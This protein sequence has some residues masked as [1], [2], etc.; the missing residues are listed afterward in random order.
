MP[1]EPDDE[2]V[3]L[4]FVKSVSQRVISLVVG[5]SFVVGSGNIRP[6]FC[7]INCFQPHLV[8]FS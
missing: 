3:H 7:K 6:L 1:N 2:F 8:G 4:F 5:G